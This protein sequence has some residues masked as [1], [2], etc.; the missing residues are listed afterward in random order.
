MTKE[1]TVDEAL[2]IDALAKTDA[3]WAP[4]RDHRTA[5]AHAAGTLWLRRRDFL[6]AGVEVGS[7][8]AAARDRMSFSRRVGKLVEAGKLVRCKPR[9]KMPGVRLTA[10]GDEESRSLCALPLLWEALDTMER[11]QAL[12]GGGD[13]RPWIRETSL[14]GAADY[15]PGDNDQKT[16]LVELRLQL[17]PALWRRW[18]EGR[19]DIARRGSYR[20][21]AVES[22]DQGETAVVLPEFKQAA[23]DRYWQTFKAEMDARKTWHDPG[24]ESEIG[25][26]PLPASMP[27]ADPMPQTV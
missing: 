2:A 1:L 25:E 26:I 9:G 18:V 6:Q 23:L 8:Q 14:I 15:L 11:M 12:A 10:T 22:F 5:G 16:A 4:F 20:L 17:A 21:A 3:L 13:R 27:T 24:S 7:G 19:A